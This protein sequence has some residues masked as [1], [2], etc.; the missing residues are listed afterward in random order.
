MFQGHYPLSQDH[1]QTQSFWPPG[2]SES[3]ILA[4]NVLR[5]L[6]NSP[7][8]LADLNPLA[9]GHN[10]TSAAAGNSRVQNFA[11]HAV[12]A[13]IAGVSLRTRQLARELRTAPVTVKIC[14]LHMPA[15]MQYSC[16]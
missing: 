6:L 9:H 3:Q 1:E 8:Q 7:F 11:A 16:R 10:D 12:T 13:P 15:S 14:F 5:G 2:Q 4:Q